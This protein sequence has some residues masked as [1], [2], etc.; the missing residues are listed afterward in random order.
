MSRIRQKRAEEGAD[1]LQNQLRG[2]KRAAGAYLL[3]H[4]VHNRVHLIMLRK[5]SYNA[6]HNA[7]KT[8]L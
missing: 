6:N 4:C 8:T 5:C 7:P 1:T 3:L 2:A